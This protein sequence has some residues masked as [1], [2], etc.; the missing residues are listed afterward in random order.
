M[1]HPRQIRAARALLGWSAR[2]LAR[3]AGVHARTVQRL[4][5]PQARAAG[6]GRPGVRAVG[7]LAKVERA[8]AHAG[9]TFLDQGGRG[10]GG[11]DAGNS[12]GAAMSVAWRD[13]DDS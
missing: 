10:E 13:P 9:V 3:R 5:R 8:L 2:D 1:I 6:A 12:G 7:T 11:M 4:E